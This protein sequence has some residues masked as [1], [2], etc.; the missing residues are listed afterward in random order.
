MKEATLKV[1][2]QGFDR[3]VIYKFLRQLAV[4]ALAQRAAQL[5]LSVPE[6]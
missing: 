3:L 6:S 5:K 1:P 2:L 4:A